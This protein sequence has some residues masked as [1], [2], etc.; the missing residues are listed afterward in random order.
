AD[1]DQVVLERGVVDLLIAA[2]AHGYALVCVTNQSGIARGLIPWRAYQAVQD[3]I[4]GLLAMRGLG[5]DAVALCPMHPD[6]TGA[7]RGEHPW[8][9][10]GPGMLDAA[11]D[12]LN[13]DLS[14]S[15]I[16]GDAA[17]DLEA[18]RAA[19]LPRGALALTGHGRR[20]RAAAEALARDGF[21]VSVVDHPG[22]AM[23]LLETVDG[24]GLSD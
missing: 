18:G 21:A 14:R 16:V 15:L 24:A 20:D 22:G 11:R 5:F 1:P 8:R 6:G 2:R 17:R 4:A 3:R 12:A 13:L 19:G 7:L 23:H 10:P 9:K